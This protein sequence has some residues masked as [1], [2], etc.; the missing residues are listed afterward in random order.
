M[1]TK[2]I[3][4]QPTNVRIPEQLLEMLNEVLKETN[5]YGQMKYATTFDRVETGVV[6]EEEFGKKRMKLAKL[7]CIENNLKEN[8]IPWKNYCD[9]ISRPSLTI[10]NSVLKLIKQIQCPQPQTESMSDSN[11]LGIC[12][13]CACFFCVRKLADTD[14]DGDGRI[15]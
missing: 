5:T 14:L 6:T 1:V 15:S 12:A 9:T 11:Y 7:L 2:I 3:F 13:Q 10:Q 4:V 8:S